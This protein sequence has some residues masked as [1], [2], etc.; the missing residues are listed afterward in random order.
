MD[1]KDLEKAFS[2]ALRY[3]SHRPRTSFE[4]KNF[5]LKKFFSEDVINKVITK[6]ISNKMIDDK[7]FARMFSVDAV[8]LKQ[9]SKK[10]LLN[11]LLQKGI[12]K[13]LAVDTI[14]SI[15]K[16][17]DENILIQKVIDKKFK[18]KKIKDLNDLQKQK[19]FQFLLR[20]GFLSEDISKVLKINFE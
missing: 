20:R 14:A 12:E 5:L 8:S 13:N 1:K 9:L 7:E 17:I 3:R 19:L 10:V 4:I 15:Y 18:M 6:F 11:K 2:S 16:T